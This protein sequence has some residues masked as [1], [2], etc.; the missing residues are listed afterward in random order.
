MVSSSTGTASCTSRGFWVTF[1]GKGNLEEVRND[2]GW[3]TSDDSGILYFKLG[4]SEL[5]LL[6]K[7]PQ[8][9]FGW[10][11]GSSQMFVSHNIHKCVIYSLA[12]IKYYIKRKNQEKKKAQREAK[13]IFKWSSGLICPHLLRVGVRGSL[14]RPQ[15]G[16][17]VLASLVQHSTGP[18]PALRVSTR[19]VIFSTTFNCSFFFPLL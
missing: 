11:G 15:L 4:I 12:Y 17:P 6:E 13:V 7:K 14:R 1:L 5:L 8:R 18:E 3:Q 9:K 2:T 10:G 19:T 16:W